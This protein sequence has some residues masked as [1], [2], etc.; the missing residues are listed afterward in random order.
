MFY[1]LRD[2]IFKK[3]KILLKRDPFKEENTGIEKR[4]TLPVGGGVMDNFNFLS[5]EIKKSITLAYLNIF[6]IIFINCREGRGKEK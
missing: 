4:T 6:K 5:T 2:C 1:G 3:T